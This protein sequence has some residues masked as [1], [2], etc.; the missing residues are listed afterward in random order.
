MFK[1][2]WV[3]LVCLSILSGCVSDR[4]KKPPGSR[5]KP[6]EVQGGAL[7]PYFGF[8]VDASY[9]NRLDGLVPGYKL[10]NVAVRNTSPF[11]VPMSPTKDRWTLVDHEGRVHR[12]MNSVKLSKVKIWRGL[13]SELRRQIEY[14]ENIPVSYEVTFN[15]MIPEKVIAEEFE[16]VHY[17]NNYW[18]RTFVITKY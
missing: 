2:T 18:K 13:P 10:L 1:K 5:T 4:V 9:D 6:I 11:I 3:L 12:L 15:L 7:I 17:Y 8:S 14:P 16:E